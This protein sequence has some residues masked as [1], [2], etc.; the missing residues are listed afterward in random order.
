VS[1]IQRI[2]LCKDKGFKAID[3]DNT[4][5][6]GSCN[7]GFPLT[8]NDALQYLQFLSDTARAIGLGVGLKNTLDLINSTTGVKSASRF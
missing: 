8:S 5:C 2:Q 7:T 4:D 6:Y 1:A 3:P